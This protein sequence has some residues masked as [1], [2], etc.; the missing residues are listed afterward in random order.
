MQGI[1]S[2]AAAAKAATANSLAPG[3]AAANG[4]AVNGAAAAAAGASHGTPLLVLYG[5]NTGGTGTSLG[6]KKHS[7]NLH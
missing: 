5:S 4:A 3:D 1:T 7:K 2:Q 6:N